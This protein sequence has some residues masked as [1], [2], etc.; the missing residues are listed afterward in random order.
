MVNLVNG[1]ELRDRE[2]TCEVRACDRKGAYPLWG[3]VEGTACSALALPSPVGWVR[4]CGFPHSPGGL[5]CWFPSVG[6]WPVPQVTVLAGCGAFIVS[7][8]FS[9]LFVFFVGG[10]L[11]V[12]G[13]FVG[14]KVGGG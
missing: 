2:G 5:C 14:R 1:S 12:G 8:G 4:S 13:W 7:F 11:W 6:G 3:E 10:L 9:V